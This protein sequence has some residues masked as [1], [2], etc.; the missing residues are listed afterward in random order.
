MNETTAELKNGEV[1]LLN[2]VL[3][4]KIPIA[5]TINVKDIN[6]TNLSSNVLLKASRQ[7]P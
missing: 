3:E 5:L 1:T 7:I 4:K 2:V 6:G